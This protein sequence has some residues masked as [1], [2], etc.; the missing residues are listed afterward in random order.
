MGTGGLFWGV[1]LNRE[2]VPLLLPF[3]DEQ[4]PRDCAPPVPLFSVL[5]QQPGFD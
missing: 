2:H 4:F 3:V 5:A 1:E